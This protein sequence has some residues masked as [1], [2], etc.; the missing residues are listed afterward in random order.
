MLILGIKLDPLFENISQYR[1]LVDKFM[2]LTVKGPYIAYVV[3]LVSQF[4]YK[5]KEIIERQS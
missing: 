2:Y 5:P 1:R 3:G 4:M